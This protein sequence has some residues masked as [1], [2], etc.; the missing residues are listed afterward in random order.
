ML[1]EIQTRLGLAF[2]GAV[3]LLT[4]AMTLFAGI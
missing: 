1:G 3:T 4:L 2:F